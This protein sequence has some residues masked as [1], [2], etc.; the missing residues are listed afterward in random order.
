MNMTKVSKTKLGLL[1]ARLR[2]FTV[3]NPRQGESRAAYLKKVKKLVR[4]K[5]K[6]G[7]HE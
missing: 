4:A 6:A 5:Q 3:E 1:L 2:G 7:K